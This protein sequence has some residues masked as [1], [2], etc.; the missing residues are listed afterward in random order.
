M[1]N[2][3]VVKNV[4]FLRQII[5][6][7]LAPTRQFSSVAYNV[8]SKFETAYET[9]MKTIRAQPKKTPEPEN[10]TEYGQGFYQQHLKNMRHITEKLIPQCDAVCWPL[11]FFHI[12]IP[13][14]RVSPPPS[15][16]PHRAGSSRP[17][18]CRA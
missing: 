15:P 2:N 13:F 8:K 4:S 16:A 3:A 7:S 18:R 10:A 14:V 9:K 17:A 12:N 6:P 11:S 5:Q 1:L